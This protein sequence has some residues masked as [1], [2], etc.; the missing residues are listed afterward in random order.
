MLPHLTITYSSQY[1]S[2]KTHLYN[3]VDL[4]LHWLKKLRA[5]VYKPRRPHKTTG[6][7]ANISNAFSELRHVSAGCGN[8]R[9]IFRKRVYI[10]KS[11]NILGITTLIKS[12]KYSRASQSKKWDGYR[13]IRAIIFKSTNVNKAFLAKSF[14]ERIP[15]DCPIQCKYF[16]SLILNDYF[17]NFVLRVVTW[18]VDSKTIFSVIRNMLTVLLSW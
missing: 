4:I 16:V 2:L 13:A 15:Y 10:Y 1:E 18:V 7:C 12:K 11:F 17:L 3:T 8:N 5:G 6:K 14:L 9:R